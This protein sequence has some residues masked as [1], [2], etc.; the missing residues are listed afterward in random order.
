[1]WDFLCFCADPNS[2]EAVP[3][4]DY[5]SAEMAGVL[6]TSDSIL[7]Q[8]APN[9]GPSRCVVPSRTRGSSC[10]QTL[11]MILSRLKASI[12]TPKKDLSSADFE[13]MIAFWHRSLPRLSPCVV[14][15]PW[16]NSS[17]FFMKRSSFKSSARTSK[18]K[19]S[20]LEMSS[21]DIVTASNG[22]SSKET[23]AR[24]KNLGKL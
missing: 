5:S 22:L 6:E 15:P 8:G 16:Q 10:S 12:G 14:S 18:R 20:N 2:T 19:I 17:P 13:D 11:Q 3:V 1:M 7:E 9:K 23:V 24:I 4:A 21:S